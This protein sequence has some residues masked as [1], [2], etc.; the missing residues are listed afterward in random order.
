MRTRYL[1]LG[2]MLFAA[3]GVRAQTTDAQPLSAIPETEAVTADPPIDHEM[4]DI[5]RL[6]FWVGN[7][8]TS[9]HDPLTDGGGLSWALPDGGALL[10][11]DWLVWVSDVGNELR[12]GGA[13]ARGGLQGG[14]FLTNGSVQDPEDSLIRVYRL[15]LV[16]RAGFAALPAERQ[17]QLRT[18]FRDWP[19]AHGAPF[20]DVDGNG[21]YEADF[22]AWLDDHDATDHPLFP[23]TQILW[24]VSND[25]DVDRSINLYGS[26]PVWTEMRLFAWAGT[27]PPLLDNTV[28][29]EYTVV[30]HLPAPY[31]Q[32][33]FGRWSDP[34]FGN[35]RDDLV[36]IDTTLGLQYAYNGTPRDSEIGSIPPAV[37][38]VWLQTPVQPA[39]G[40]TADFGFAQRADHVNIPLDA[41]T[42]FIPGDPI[43]VEPTMGDPSGVYE[44]DARMR[45]F[46]WTGKM[47]DPGSFIPTTFALAGDPVLGAGW[48]DGVFQPAGDRRSLTSTASVTLASQDTQKVTLALTVA[49]GGNHLLSVRA[50]RNSARQLHDFYRQR[51]AS[52]IPPSFT[53][54]VRH[55]G[56]TRWEIV[57]RCGPFPP[58]EDDAVRAVLHDDG[59]NEI[60][61]VTLADDGQHGDGAAGDGQYGGTLQGER[62]AA[63]GTLTVL[64]A[65]AGGEDSW[66]VDNDLPL[67]GPV[68]VSVNAIVSDHLNYNGRANPGESIRLQLRIDNGTVTDVPRWHILPA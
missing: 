52:G 55:T 50:L 66:F 17:A 30:N 68:H 8:G 65:H 49:E 46:L 47:V 20:V 12:A 43:Y 42:F 29:L 39:A 28:F 6:L 40:E 7:D 63:T 67:A 44:L 1:V 33:R 13:T 5:N 3:T 18:D 60:T 64:H 41:F 35:P 4:M 48:V 2:L 51:R 15:Q 23:G 9:A 22:E 25:M 10:Y 24:Y 31:K 45:G 54:G 37:G 26:R 21:T 58:G 53:S 14:A 59:G 56:T 27:T 62:I 11:R 16:D 19:T 61:S 36:G 38:Y 32:L 34:D 57:V